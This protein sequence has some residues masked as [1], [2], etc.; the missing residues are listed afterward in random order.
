MPGGGGAGGAVAGPGQGG[1]GGTGGVPCAAGADQDGDGLTDCTELNDQNAWTDPAIFNGMRVRWAEQCDADPSCDPAETPTRADACLAESGVRE[2]RLQSAGWS[3]AD[4]P[5]SICDPS[6]GFQP[7]WQQC[8]GGERERWQAD[9]QG[10][11][12]LAEPGQ[13]CFSVVGRES[14]ACAT[15]WFNGATTGP[16]YRTGARCY[17]VAAGVYP[18]RWYYQ[19]DDGS[20]S[21]LHVNHCF[22]GAAPCTPTLEIPSTLLRP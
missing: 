18:I 19:M 22:G 11:I 2:E 14:E 7:A 3:W 21:D 1:A 8:G 4:S 12:F 20:S 16:D 5:D 10:T 6:Y 17:T 15:L 9:W 13:H